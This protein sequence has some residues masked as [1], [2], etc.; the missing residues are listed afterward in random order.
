MGPSFGQRWGCRAREDRSTASSRN[1]ESGLAHST[2]EVPEG[3][4]GAEG[5]E[6][7]EGRGQLEGVSS[8]K[9]KVRT[10]SRAALPPHLHRVHEAAKRDRQLRFTALRHHVNVA[11]LERAFRRLRRNA[12]AGVDGETVERYER[13]L[14]ANLERLCAQ[15][16]ARRYRPR[17]VRRVYISKSDGGRRPLGIPALEDKIVQSAVAELLSAIYEA[18]FLGFSYGFRPGRNPHRALT[19]LH[20]ATMTHRVNWGPRCR[21]PQAFRLGGPRVAPADDGTPDRRPPS[22][23]ADPDGSRPGCWKMGSGPRR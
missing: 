23:A 18:D 14:S 6:G 17:S 8:Q 19:A 4:E 5:S 10:Q 15:V 11:S 3:N 9:A 2:G 20:T 21:H 13:D 22:P 1:R 16:H 7:A 12:S